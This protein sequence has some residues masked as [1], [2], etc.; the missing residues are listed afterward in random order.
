MGYAFAADA[1]M[2]LHFGFI[3]F[4]LLGSLLLL[5]WPRLIWLHLPALAWGIYIEWSGGLCPLTGYENHLRALADQSTYGE[6]FITHYLAPI[7]YPANFTRGWQYFAL[8]AL[9]LVNLLG[10]GV[11]LARRRKPVVRFV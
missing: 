6:G 5:K 3:A 1:V 4:A 7:V 9:L 2:L 11:F 10:Y 8:G